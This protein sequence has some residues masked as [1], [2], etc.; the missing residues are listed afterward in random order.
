MA[1]N[2]KAPSPWRESTRLVRGGLERTGFSETSEA[3]FMTSGYVYETA[4][5]AE[6][7]FK[8]EHKRYIYS[9]YANPTLSVFETRLAQLEGAEHCLGTASGMA[10]VFAALIGQLKAGD[11]VVAARAL[12][13]SCH[14]I[15]ADLLPRYGIET[16]F[17]DGTNLDQWAQALSKPANCVFVET[18]SNPTLEIIDLKAVADL[19]HAAGACLVIDNVFATPILQK[20]LDLGADVVTYSTTKHIDGQGRSLGGA[21]LTNDTELVEDH[22]TP[23]LRHTGPALSPFNAWLLLKG[24]ETLEL[25]VCRHCENAAIVADFLA[26]QAGVARVFYPGRTDHP[27]HDLAMRQMPGGGTMVAFEVDGGHDGAFRVLNGLQLID[28]SNNLGDAKSLI[29]HPATTTHE[30]I[31]PQE[32]AKMGIN[33]GLLRLSVGLE[34]ARDLCDDLDRALQT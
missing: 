22:L 8:G 4:E 29:T 20:P 30:R 9:R 5:E 13:G 32:R 34:D 19:A 25:R 18:P 31:G 27:Q 6:R 7:A 24:L 2:D 12:F 16:E 23:F 33:D 26:D 14:Y 17:V 3:L 28:I 11:R 21:I 1:R 15:I 10:A